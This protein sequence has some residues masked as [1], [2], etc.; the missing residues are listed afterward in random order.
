MRV[1]P[2]D[3]AVAEGILFLTPEPRG[4]VRTQDYNT[5]VTELVSPSVTQRSHS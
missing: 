1:I 5:T 4:S 3:V 2:I